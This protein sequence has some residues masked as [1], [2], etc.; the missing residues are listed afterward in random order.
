MPEIG[1]VAGRRFEIRFVRELRAG[2]SFH[3]LSGAIA[4]DEHSV[5]FGHRFID[6][7]SA[8]TVAWAEETIDG[9]PSAARDTI[10]RHLVDWPGPAVERRPEPK[11]LDGLRPSA[12]DRVKPSGLDHLRCGPPAAF[13]HRFTTSLRQTLAGLRQ[14]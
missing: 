5:R 4:F 2:D 12:R 7:A 11:T 13:V 1:Q 14:G 8:E 6:S 3:I 9:L 10:G